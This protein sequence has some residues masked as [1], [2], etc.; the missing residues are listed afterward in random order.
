MEYKTKQVIVVRKD[1]NMR[2]GKVAAQ[3][4]HASMAFLTRKASVTPFGVKEKNC[5][6]FST[7]LSPPEFAAEVDHW[8][9]FSFAKICVYVNSEQELLDIHNMAMAKGL[10]S[11]LITDSGKTEFN[12]VPTNTCIAI[13]PHK[14][15]KFEGVTSHLPLL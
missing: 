6:E 3:A 1:L 5:Y 10:E 7:L 4:S 11:H 14:V 2:Q 8:M 12:N 15:E 9:H 13:G